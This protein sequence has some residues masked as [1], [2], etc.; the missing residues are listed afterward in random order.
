MR[1]SVMA[2]VLPFMSTG[3]IATSKKPEV[4]TVVSIV[5]IDAVIKRVITL[6]QQNE[7]QK[8]IE[9]LLTTVNKQKEDTILRTLLVETFDLF[10]EDEIKVGQVAIKKNPKIVSNYYRVAGALE[11]LSDNFHAMEVLLTALQYHPDVPELW[12]KIARLELAA[13]R[14]L[15]ALDVFKEVIRLD[16]RNSDAYNNAAYI[17]AKADRANDRDLNEA[18]EL[19]KSACKLDP[20]NPEYIDT[21]A[22]VSFRKGNVENAKVLIEEAIRLAPKNDAFQNQLRRFSP[23]G[24]LPT[25]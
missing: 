6:N 24:P 11:L 22:E 7:H 25:P 2:L 21:L 17:L 12:M 3:F 16:Q 5:D 20:K 15:E 9:L 13:D 23:P 10:L 8:A 4:N 18:E 14:N 1:Y 19:A